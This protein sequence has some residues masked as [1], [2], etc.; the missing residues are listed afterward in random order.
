[1]ELTINR[2]ESGDVA[3]LDLSGRLV[4]GAEATRLREELMTLV[5]ARQPKVLLNLEGLGFVDSSG[6]GALVG[7]ASAAKAL[8]VQLK[9]VKPSATL[10]KVLEI[11]HLTHILDIREDEQDALDSFD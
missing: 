9:F 11:A 7:T 1:M 5:N 10:R 4:M 2:R 6:M 3:I 8:G